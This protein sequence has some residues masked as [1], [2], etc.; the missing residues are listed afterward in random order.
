MQARLLVISHVF[1]NVHAVI[2]QKR[3]GPFCR[4]FGQ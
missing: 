2:E 4:Q 3:S 1:A